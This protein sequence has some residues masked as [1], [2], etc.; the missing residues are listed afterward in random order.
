MEIKNLSFRVDSSVKKQIDLL[1]FTDQEN[2][3]LQNFKKILR[4]N[5]PYNLRYFWD[6]FYRASN[7]FNEPEFWERKFSIIHSLKYRKLFGKLENYLLNRLKFLLKS[8]KKPNIE[9]SIEYIQFLQLCKVKIKYKQNVKNIKMFLYSLPNCVNNEKLLLM[10][11]SVFP[12][13]C[14]S[15][16]DYICQV[17]KIYKKFPNI[18]GFV[19]FL[20][21]KNIFVDKEEIIKIINDYFFGKNPPA[22]MFR[23]SILLEIISNNIGLE[24]I[25]KIYNI[26]NKNKIIV[27]IKNLSFSQLEGQYF[28]H[29]KNLLSI[30]DSLVDNIME[31]YLEKLYTRTVYH[32]RAN[33][34]RIIKL[35]QLS[36]LIN[37]KKVINW[38]SKNNRTS[39]A[40][41]FMKK[42]PEFSRLAAF[43]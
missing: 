5:A 30:D 41:Y 23:S 26:N 11:Q 14:K 9:K 13:I 28:I 2:V 7:I 8:R 24:I 33:T 29:I 4:S 16:T 20:E 38:L 34:D 12:D 40:Q 21:R 6:A 39:D 15:A 18:F 42:F 17:L 19:D 37:F 1:L 27:L 35:N 43:V 10:T 22:L 31:I 25:K 3:N 32:K 36:P